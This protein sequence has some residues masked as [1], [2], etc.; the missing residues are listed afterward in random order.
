MPIK[1]PPEWV[2]LEATMHEDYTI[3]LEFADMS[4]RI[5]DAHAL[6]EDDFWK[7]LNDLDF[8]MGGRAAHGTVVWSDTVD[9]A[10]ETLYYDSVV[11]E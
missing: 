5:Y 11:V 3:D 8:F 2:V 9:I 10:P 6:L 1:N 7:D 4:H